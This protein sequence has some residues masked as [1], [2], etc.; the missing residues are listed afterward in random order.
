[1]TI[2]YSSNSRTHPLYWALLCLSP[3]FILSYSVYSLGMDYGLGCLVL[4]LA[5]LNLRSS[6]PS[7][8]R[9]SLVLAMVLFAMAIYQFSF[10]AFALP[11]FIYSCL[12]PDNKKLTAETNDVLLS[13]I[14]CIVFIVLSVWRIFFGL[15]WSQFQ[16][17]LFQKTELFYLGF[18]CLALL[19]L[20]PIFFIRLHQLD[21]AFY[22]FGLLSIFCLVGFGFD[23]GYC[24]TIFCTLIFISLIFNFRSVIFRPSVARISVLTITLYSLLWSIPMPFVGIPGLGVY[25]ALYEAYPRLAMEDPLKH[26]FWRE[27][28]DRYTQVEIGQVRN[29]LPPDSQ[30]LEFLLK[31]AGIKHIVFQEYLNADLQ[32]GDSDFNTFYI[33]DDWRFNPSFRFVPNPSVD[34]L[35]RID[36]YLVYA[37][38]WKVCKQCR[39]IAPDLQ[40]AAL[41]SV[42]KVDEV[43]KFGD[44][45]S[46]RYL[47]ADGWALPES[48]GVWSSAKLASIYFPKPQQGAKTLE[49]NLR[50]F[51]A[52]NHPNQEVSVLLDG[53]LIGTYSLAKGEGNV[54]NIPLSSTANNFYRV[55]FQMHNPIR[56]VD[57]GFNQDQRLLGVALV[58]AR[59]K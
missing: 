3:A 44:T 17:A 57:L 26:P 55:D 29:G 6:V 37:P 23:W 28:A 49:L 54:L 27:A 30:K 52:P 59:F 45:S 11:F 8:S 14:A 21:W 34:L 22:G 5:F 4:A 53:K 1:M 48:W 2:D 12:A 24:L 41:P 9:W 33:L 36:G 15:D 10:A 35:A 38:G 39:E 31:R 13:R 19:A 32:V 25:G 7:K 50:A 42:F 47:L 46:G 43:I 51:I 16:P 56:P 58:S 20:L 18:L 40:I